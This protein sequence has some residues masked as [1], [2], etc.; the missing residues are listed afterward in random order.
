[1]LSNYLFY[2]RRNMRKRIK[3]GEEKGKKLIGRLK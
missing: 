1:M 2:L 3:E